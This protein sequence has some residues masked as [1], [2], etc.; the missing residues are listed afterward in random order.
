MLFSTLSFGFVL[1]Q[2]VTASP[3]SDTARIETHDVGPRAAPIA[4]LPWPGLPA[5]RRA[6]KS[7]TSGKKDC[8][9][10]SQQG[11]ACSSGTQ[12]C[13]TTSSDGSSTCAHSEVCTAK[14]ICCNNNSGYQMCI[15]EVDFNGPVT[16]N[17]NIYNG[18]KGGGKGGKGG[19]KLSA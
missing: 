15:G 18:G 5:L 7:V 4:N 16:I 8:P 17:I 14:I 13:C 1:L 2:G 3:V 6:D 11:N 12:Y 9:G 19:Y 10:T